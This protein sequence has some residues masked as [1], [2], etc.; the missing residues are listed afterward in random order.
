MSDEASGDKPVLVHSIAEAYLH[1]K[2]TRCPACRQGPL[3][4]SEDLTRTPSAPGGWT[5]NAV[6]EGCGVKQSV[7]FEIQPPPSRADAAST[8]I[9]PTPSRSE[10]IDLL[11]WLTLSQAIIEA[12]EKEKDKQAGRQLAYEAALCLD[13]ALKFYNATEELPGEDAFFSPE[14]LNRF[15]SHPERFAKSQWRQRRL[16]LPDLAAKVQPAKSRGARRWW[17]FW[18]R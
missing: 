3:R 11:G 5:L 2:I 6:C 14:S 13:E 16:L 1:L 7:Y 15:R 8:I 10:A 12:C 18:R 4:E 17:R 9:N